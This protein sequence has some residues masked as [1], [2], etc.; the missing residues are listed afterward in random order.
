MAVIDFLPDRL[1]YPPVVWRGYTA[2]EF[3]LAA[4]LGAIAGIPLAVP[5]AFIP[6]L[7][8]FA[9]PVCIL[10]MP[11]VTLFLGG[12]WI[13]RYKRGKPENHIW[14]QLEVLRCRLRFSSSLLLVSRTW[15]IRRTGNLKQRQ[16]P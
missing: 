1:N 2:G 9:F 3:L 7:G 12:R 13:A 5:L 16:K 14:Q 4:A 11:M 8:W 15:D 6:F 10:L